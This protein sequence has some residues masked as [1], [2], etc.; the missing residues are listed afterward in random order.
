MEQPLKQPFTEQELEMVQ[1]PGDVPQGMVTSS[2]YYPFGKRTGWD[3]GKRC[4]YDLQNLPKW[5]LDAADQW[6]FRGLKESYSGEELRIT[7]GYK[8]SGV[9]TLQPR[10]GSVED[11]LQRIAP[12]LRSACVSTEQKRA[13]CGLLFY[14]LFKLTDTKEPEKMDFA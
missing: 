14:R 13:T 5:T 2:D 11:N 7:F 6:F 1:I 3:E 12:L 10:Q 4:S 8:G 9:Y